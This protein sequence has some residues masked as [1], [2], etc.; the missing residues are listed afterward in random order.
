MIEPRARIFCKPNDIVAGFRHLPIRKQFNELF[1]NRTGPYSLKRRSNAMLYGARTKLQG[2]IAFFVFFVRMV[3]GRN[4][5]G[6][7]GERQAAPPLAELF[8]RGTSEQK[9]GSGPTVRKIGGLT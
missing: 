7:W 3:V 6:R 4:I 9:P 1:L 8:G 2:M 5:E